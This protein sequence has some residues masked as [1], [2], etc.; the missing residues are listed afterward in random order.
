MLQRAWQKTEQL[1]MKLSEQL[2]QTNWQ[3]SK[4]I[5]NQLKNMQS[6]KRSACQTNELLLSS[7]MAEKIW[8]KGETKSQQTY[9]I[10]RDQSL[11]QLF[12]KVAL[13]DYRNANNWM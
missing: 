5:D 8:P 11:Y 1:S 4:R 12:K 10:K 6:K 3:L 9:D 7:A 13:R 2:S